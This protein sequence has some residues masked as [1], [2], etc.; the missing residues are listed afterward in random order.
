VNQQPL[1]LEKG[2]LEG[3]LEG[4]LHLILNLVQQTDFSD[5]KIAALAEVE[6]LLVQQVRA[7]VAAG[8]TDLSDLMPR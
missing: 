5:E 3:K 8:N 6:L 2:K 4:T 7:R 1:G